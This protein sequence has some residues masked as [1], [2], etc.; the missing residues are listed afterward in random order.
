MRKSRAPS[1]L[2]RTSAADLL[3]VPLYL[4][5]SETR[6]VMKKMFGKEDKMV[7]GCRSGGQEV[8]DGR[9]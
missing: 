6:V 3:R 7:V 5:F 9:F 8:E 4:S 2:W 1:H